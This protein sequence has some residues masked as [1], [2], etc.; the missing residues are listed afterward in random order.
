MTYQ[1][2]FFDLDHTL[3]DHHKNA[4]ETLEDLYRDYNLGH[5][6][7][8]SSA[9]FIKSFHEINHTLWDKYNHGQLDQ[10]YIRQNRFPLVLNTFGIEQQQVPVGLAEAYLQQCP[11]KPHLMPHTLPVLEYLNKR[12]EMSIITNGF[13]DVQDIKMSCSGLLKYFDHIITSEQ[14]GKLKP[15]PQ[16]FD[17]A[18][19]TVQLTKEACIMIGDNAST[20]IAGAQAI[21]M[22]Q[23]YYDPQNQQQATNPTYT[24]KSLQELQ[25]L[26]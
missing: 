7:R 26:L 25:E 22:D 24:V 14:A 13:S 4:N 16:I 11:Q 2:L 6:A 3:W 23:I 1:H 10:L 18:L 5:L 17:F 8:F 12:Y 15:H 20:D 9:D 21:G 19:Q